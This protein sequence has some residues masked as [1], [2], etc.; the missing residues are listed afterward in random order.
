MRNANGEQARVKL[1]DI[2]EVELKPLAFKEKLNRLLLSFQMVVV[3]T[4]M[5]IVNFVMLAV[6]QLLVRENIKAAHSSSALKNLQLALSIVVFTINTAFLLEVILQVAA[7][8]GTAYLQNVWSGFD[9]FI[10]T[11]LFALEVASRAGW[12]DPTAGIWHFLIVLRL[13]RVLA[14][15]SQHTSTVIAEK[16]EER[17]RLEAQI[18]QLRGRMAQEDDKNSKLRAE[19]QEAVLYL[20]TIEKSLVHSRENAKV[21]LRRYSMA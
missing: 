11:L 14:L 17:V 18:V 15:M 10:I 5:V 12:K 16:K 7:G 2:R 9:S 21:L 6:T 1:L 20:C 19:L 13:I 8:Q 3:T 4:L